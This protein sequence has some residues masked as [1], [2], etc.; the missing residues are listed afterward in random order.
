MF[1]CPLLDVVFGLDLT[2]TS[3]V[4]PVSFARSTPRLIVTHNR[5]QG[6]NNSG[7]V[8]LPAEMRLRVSGIWV[9]GAI[10]ELFIHRYP[11][12]KFSP[13]GMSGPRIYS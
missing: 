9:I 12:E 8:R 10:V 4:L 5:P 3:S 2:P 11:Q 1:R 6:V 13:V 7:V